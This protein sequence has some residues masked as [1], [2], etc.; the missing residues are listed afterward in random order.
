MKV[1]RYV[2]GTDIYRSA[3]YGADPNQS[4]D[5]LGLDGGTPSPKGHSSVSCVHYIL[6]L[7]PVAL[8]DIHTCKAK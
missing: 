2:L 7:L 1:I 8:S 3:H 4:S 5:L 6:V